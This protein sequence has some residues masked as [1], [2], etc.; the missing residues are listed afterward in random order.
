MIL[1]RAYITFSHIDTMV[2]GFHK[3]ICCFGLFDDAFHCHRRLIVHDIQLRVA[4]VVSY[5]L[6]QI[7]VHVD[8]ILITTIFHGPE[9]DEIES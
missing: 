7:C 3:L 4:V 5:V 8:C 1:E 6:I 2:V 9:K